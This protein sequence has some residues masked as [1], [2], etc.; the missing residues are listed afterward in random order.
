[1][2]NLTAVLPLL[3]VGGVTGFAALLARA[4]LQALRATSEVSEEKNRTITRLE[5]TVERQDREID[6]LNSRLLTALRDSVMKDAEIAALRQRGTA[7]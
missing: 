6:D 5:A 2:D 3:G 1:M 4:W 7:S